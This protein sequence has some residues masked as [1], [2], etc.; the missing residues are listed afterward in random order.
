[1]L[2]EKKP[3]SLFSATILVIANMIGTGVFTTLGFQLADVHSPFS[4]IMLWV[5]G[6]IVS[7]C[8]ALSYGELGA[9]MPRSGG[10]Y[11]YLTEIYHPA[12]GFLTGSVSILVGFGAPIALAAMALGRYSGAAFPGVDE[13]VVAVAA[14]VVITLVHLV[15]VRFGCH[16]QNLFTVGKILLIAV[17]IVAGFSMPDPQEIVIPQSLGELGAVFSPAFA[18]GLVYVSFAYSGWNASAYIA[19]EIPR[20]ERNL[21]LSLF[22]GTLCV[23]LCYILL[24]VVFLL[25]VPAAELT[26]K[27]EVGY[28]SAKAV[29]GEG[30]VRLMTLLICLA[31][32]S[33]L[34]SMIMVGPR[35]A[36][37][38]GEDIRA[39]G[40]LAVRSPGGVPVRAMLIQSSVAILLAL[41]SAF[42]FVLTYVGFTLTLFT[43]MAV[44]GVFVLRFKE[45]HRARPFKTW[46][47]PVVPALFLAVNGWMLCYLV[48]QRPLPSA[49]CLMTVASLLILYRW[50]TNRQGE[51][52][53]L[54]EEKR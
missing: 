53:L 26:G 35:V 22:L 10:E 16:F 13:T 40:F 5:V 28:F 20:P 39:L 24:N 21:S 3:V 30:G 54:Q 12:V 19:G 32:I 42:N 25:T 50:L 9:M 48:I 27:I 52:D 34:G 7:F 49:F 11:A 17:F 37:A 18:V 14:I 36:A 15:D 38:M 4:A 31:L 43:C 23:S 29:F 47:Y 44:L 6:G 2:N 1:M 51:S 33:S 46:G 8:G 41:T 45:P